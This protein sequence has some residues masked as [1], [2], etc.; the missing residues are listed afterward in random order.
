[1]HGSHCLKHWSSTQTTLS[2]STAESELHGICKSMQMGIGFRSL[3]K[4]LDMHMKIR[5]HSDATAAI[6][7]ARKK[8]LRKLR[9]LDVENLWCQ[10]KIRDKTI[11]ISKILG[12]DNPADIFTKYVDSAT[13]QKALKRMGLNAEA[14][15]AKSATG[16]FICVSLQIHSFTRLSYLFRLSYGPWHVESMYFENLSQ[17]NCLQSQEGCCGKCVAAPPYL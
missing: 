3:C 1:M 6:G 16:L 11:E 17:G 8:G 15:R 13:L 2:L 5:L 7:I 4:D 9:H 12:T 10:E 14:G